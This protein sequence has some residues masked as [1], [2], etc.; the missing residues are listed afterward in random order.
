MLIVLLG[1]G[2]PARCTE[3]TA[4]QIL[5]RREA[6]EQTTRWWNDRYQRMRLTVD[7][8]D[9]A[10][11]H[12]EIETFDRRQHGRS[13]QELVVFIAPAEKAGVALLGHIEAGKPAQQW[14]YSPASRRVR[15]VARD[16]RQERFDIT[17]FTY[18]D[19]DILTDMPHWTEEDARSTLQPPDTIA[20]VP[21][22]V[23]DLEPRLA[24]IPYGRV[25]LW[26]GRDDLVPRQ[27]EFYPRPTDTRI[28]SSLTARLF[29]GP[30]G[31]RPVRRFRQS[32][33]RTV[34]AIPVAYR[35]EAETPDERTRTLIEIVEVSFEKGLSEG[36]F[37]PASLGAKSH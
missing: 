3:E 28:L 19:L 31:E 10:P 8:D 24:H 5:D 13:E 1:S 2:R 30:A 27:V 7:A 18:A 16:A 20:G 33:V 22:H 34:G 23:I 29:A 37:S 21:C 4:R 26:L 9:T 32:D 35:V 17:D 36:F 25:R 12:L 15:Q 14:L 11:R 6:L